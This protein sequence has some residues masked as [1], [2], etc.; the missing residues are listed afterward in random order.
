M[1]KINILSVFILLF[2]AGHTFAQN[3]E[4]S[5]NNFPND[6]K[7]LK[8]AQTNIAAGDKLYFLG[9]GRWVD[10]IEFYTLANEFNPNNALL[11]YKLGRCYM[12]TSDKHKAL[13]YL[14]KAHQ[15]NTAV[16]GDVL[17]QIAEA[18]HQIHNFEKAIQKYREYKNALTPKSLAEIG[19][20][21]DKK[22]KECETG[23]MLQENP[24]RAFIDN[25]GAGINT[26]YPEYSPIINAD[27]SMIIFTSRRNTTTGG[28][29]APDDEKYYEDII[30]SYRLGTGDWGAAQN[31]GKPLNSELHDATVGLS[32]DGQTLYI[33]RG[34]NGGDIY[35]CFLKGDS[36][37]KPE[38]LNKN[39]NTKYHESSA[40]L[41]PDGRKLYF[42]SDKPSGFGGRDIYVSELD[43]K[44]NWCPAKILPSSINT[45]FDEEAVFA[46][47]DGRTLYFSSKGHNTMG[48]FDIFYSVFENG[49]WSTPVN[50]GYPINTAGDDVFFSIS[51]SGRHGYYSSA[52][53]GGLGDQDLYVITFLGAEKPMVNN[54]DDNLLA[55][56][57]A[58]MS[59][60]VIE[61]LIDIQTTSLTLLKGRILDEVTHEPVEASILLTDI[62]KNEELAT[63]TSNSAT[64][65]YLV[66]LPSGKNYGIAVSAEGYLFHSENFNIPDKATYQ[67]IEKDIYLKKI[68]V[69]SSIVLKNIFFDFNQATLRPES[70]NELDRL[71]ALLNDM[72]SLKIEISGHTDNIGSAQYNKTLSERRAKSV[73]DYL[74]ENGISPNRL[75]YKGYGFDMPIAPNDTEE[76]R[77]QNRRT[78]FKI[79]SN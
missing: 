45:P 58:A 44:G 26:M 6:K 73:V 74:I 78:E 21:I 75:T 67:E 16:E 48:G 7:G 29:R 11:N 17:F 27:E 52:R 25:M 62:D 28:N 22:I 35:D 23:K 51:A 72:P 12:K 61:K 63:F 33:Y 47:P 53:P 24:V 15:L 3:V 5:K 71:V 40:S 2:I 77:Q 1:K 38:R 30:I 10:A 37:T 4:F 13:I 14:E 39:I 8:E 64:G 34:D 60:Q 68:A 9:E 55:W 79:I 70:K 59:E 69:G 76:G 20:S 32:P 65:R 19:K 49:A 66:S 36:W 31:P 56:K 50:I 46:H 54:S 42:V 41:S 57:N 43:K 18:Y